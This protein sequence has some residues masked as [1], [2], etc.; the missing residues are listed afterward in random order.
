MQDHFCYKAS[1]GAAHHC[2][3]K[4]RETKPSYRTSRRLQ[5]C[6]GI[7]ECRCSLRQGVDGP[8]GYRVTFTETD[9]IQ[10]IKLTDKYGKEP[11]NRSMAVDQIRSGRIV[12][13]PGRIDIRRAVELTWARQIVESPSL[14]VLN[15]Q[16]MG[17][18]NPGDAYIK[19]FGSAERPVYRVLVCGHSGRKRWAVTIFPR[20]RFAE[21][22]IAKVLWP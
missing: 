13:H 3:D 15:W 14:I 21:R 7:E 1:F 18:A 8:R 6:I 9:F 19:N 17:R 16:V 2:Q 22:E 20:E 10:L 5:C 4:Q 11:R 12:I